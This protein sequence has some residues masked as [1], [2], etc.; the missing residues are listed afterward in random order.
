GVHLLIDEGS[1]SRRHAEVKYANGQYILHDLGSTNGTFINEVRLKPA[2]PQTLKLNDQVRFGNKIKFAF[3]LRTISN[4]QAKPPAV[5]SVSMAGI[6]KLHEMQA[7]EEYTQ[8]GQP[9]LNPDGSLLLSGATNAIP[10]ALVESF[11]KYPALIV[12][13]GNASKE[14]NRPPLVYLLKQK[15]HIMI[16]RDKGNDIELADVVVSRRHAEIF[17]GP[18]GFYIR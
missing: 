18:E 17:L 2:N 13:T 15:K 7:S 10:A 8:Q 14:G 11:Q 3:L 16:G 4:A 6:T 1:V 9:M 12:L 5:T